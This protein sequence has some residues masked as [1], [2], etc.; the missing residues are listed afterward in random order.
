M[1]SVSNNYFSFEGKCCWVHTKLLFLN[2]SVRIKRVK[3]TDF[4]EHFSMDIYDDDFRRFYQMDRSTFRVLTGFLN[5]KS[6]TYQGGRVQ[7]GP[8]KMVAVTLCYLGS[9]FTY[10]QLSG[11]FGLSDQ[12]V[13]Q[14][15]EYIMKLLNDKCKFVIKWLKKENYS[16]I[17]SEFNNKARRQFPNIIG[18]I[19]GCHIHISHAKNEAQAYYNYK[20]FHSIQLQAVCLYDHKFTDIFVG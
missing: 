15:T 5:P 12:W 13:F 20:N 19:D 7:V 1:V 2:C 10:R 6:R 17:A 9:Q 18:A 16:T 8:H 3:P 11:L 14:V 4:W